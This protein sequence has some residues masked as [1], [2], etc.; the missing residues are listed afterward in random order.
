MANS[1]GSGY[2][3]PNDKNGVQNRPDFKGV[4]SLNQ[5]DWYVS[6]WV[7]EELIS[8]SFIKK[9]VNYSDSNKDDAGS[10]SELTKSSPK[11]PDMGGVVVIDGNNYEIKAWKKSKDGVD[12]YSFVLQD[13]NDQSWKNKNNSSNNSQTNESSSSSDDSPFGNVFDGLPD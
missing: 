13:P 6:G 9:G 8:L 3:Y 12:F 1:A 11:Y 5:V 4:L 2:I 7:K 10:L